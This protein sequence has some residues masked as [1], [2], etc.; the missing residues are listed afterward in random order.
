MKKI[1]WTI[2]I[3]AALAFGF[4]SCDYERGELE[5]RLRRVSVTHFWAKKLK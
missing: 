3:L 2:L 1:T 5:P 4:A